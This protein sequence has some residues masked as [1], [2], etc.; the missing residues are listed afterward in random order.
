MQKYK[1]NL[2]QWKISPVFIKLCTNCGHRLGQVIVPDFIPVNQ[3]TRY[4]LEVANRENF[5][6]GLSGPC[7]KENQV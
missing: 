3:R 5:I 2:S 6:D 1:L 7:W 4:V